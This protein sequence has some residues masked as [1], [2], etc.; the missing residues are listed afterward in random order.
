MKIKKA[1]LEEI[2]GRDKHLISFRKGILG[3]EDDKQYVL[4]PAD[5]TGESPFFFLQSAENAEVRFLLLDA[6]SFFQGYDVRLEEAVI[7]KLEIEQ[8]EDVLVLTTVTAQGDLHQATTNL[9]APLVINLKKQMGMQI[10]LDRKHYKIKQ[11]L[12]ER[13]QKA[14]I[15]QV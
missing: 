4:L 1:R 6:F 13:N 2:E 3:F 10:V 14:V 9:K 11:P 12:F 15:G 5:E 8:P 7:E